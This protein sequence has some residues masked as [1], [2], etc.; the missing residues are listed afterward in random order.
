MLQGNFINKVLFFSFLIGATVT[1]SVADVQAQKTLLNVSMIRR[2]NF[3]GSS[4]RLLPNT[5]KTALVFVRPHL[6]EIDHHSNGKDEFS[7]KIEHINAAGPV[8]RVALVSE[9]GDPV[10]VEITHE[11]FRE[12]DLHKDKKVFLRPKERRVFVNAEDNFQ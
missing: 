12:L 6:L 10:N 5:A 7:A 2:A 8:V 11:R 9:W 1:F 4:T 3:I